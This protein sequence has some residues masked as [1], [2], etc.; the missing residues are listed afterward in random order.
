MKVNLNI[1]K[2]FLDFELPPVNELVERINQQLGGVEEVIDLGSKY[3]DVVIVKVVKC[4]KHPDADRLSVCAIDDGGNTPD[5][6]RDE[7]GLIQVVCG[8]PN[9]QADMLAVWLPPKSVVPASFNDKEPFVLQ[10]RELR[11]VISNGM[12]AAGDELDINSDHEGIVEITEK[13]IMPQNSPLQ[14]PSLKELVGRSFAEVFGLNDWVIDI[15]NKMF[16]HRPD[17]F[18]QMGVAREINA[19]LQPEP[20]KTFVDNRYENPDW[21]WKIPEP[22]NTNNELELDVQNEASDKVPR[23]MATAIANVEVRPS[24]LWLQCALVAMGSKPINNIVDI[25]NYLM[26]LTAQ[27]T[28]AYDYD[29]LHGHKLVARMAQKSEKVTLLNGKTYELTDEDIVIAD[30]EGVVGV[31]GIM[32]GLDSEVTNETKNIVLE[33]ANFDM[34]AIRK[35]SMRH[36]LFTDAVTRFNKGQSKL[37]NDRVMSQLIDQISEYSGGQ[38]AS[39]VFDNP[40]ADYDKTTLCSELAV[41]SSFI[42]ERLGL[43]LSGEQIE[44]ILRAANFAIYQDE[45]DK[46]T[47]LVTAPFWRTDIE[48]PEDVVEEVGRLY[49]FDKL[50]HELPHRAINPAK[51]NLTIEAKAK[52]RSSLSRAGANEVLT[53]SFVNEKVINKAEQDITQAF[54]ISNAL[55][56]DLQY[57]RLSVLP[58]LLDKV[59]AN[60]KAGYDEFALFEIGKGHNKK[61]HANDDDDLPAEMDFVDLVYTSK[62]PQSGAAYYHA[63]GLME[64]LVADLGFGVKLSPIKEPLD[65]PV[66]APFN[67]NRSALIESRQG[68]FIGM[69]GELKQSVLRGFKLPAYTAA[70]TLDLQGLQKASQ[71]GK[72]Q[73]LSRYPAVT[74]DI[75]L[76]VDAGVLYE[77]VSA[78]FWQALAQKVDGESVVVAPLT[79][80]QSP[81]DT[82]TKTITLRVKIASYDKTLTASEVSQVLDH[83]AS[84]LKIK[85]KAERI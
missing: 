59:H 85:L 39:Q 58:S 37:Q 66:T 14:G 17:C 69:I 42:N 45:N 10:A 62:K 79:I 70:L 8:A 61:F 2:Q 56:P 7:N 53:Y 40:V 22:R 36:G 21:Y 50:P 5:V 81:D 82:K 41:S 34:Y 84:E 29:K 49:G 9:V 13:D 78:S 55:S 46:E 16:T 80:Y 27:P 19:I 65:F 3:K 71:P 30:G 47:L 51:A 44:F 77:D 68:E 33:C 26:L 32:G 43:Q 48:I 6:K 63:L 24:P 18:G 15:E 76:K 20:P 74:Q 52:I 35:T 25:T 67:Q 60:I 54:K 11:G 73:P 1:V 38:L 28:H 83:V 31:G 72:Y 4:E 12:L 64:Q 75:S 23:F 57:Y